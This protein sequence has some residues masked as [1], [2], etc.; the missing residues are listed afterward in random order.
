MKIWILEDEDFA[1]RKIANLL[2]KILPNAEVGEP[3]ESVKEATQALSK[4]QPDLL[5]ADIHLSDGLSFELFDNVQVE[6]P[7]IFTTA[8]DEYALKAF[9][10]MSVDYLLKPISE[11]QLRKAIDKLDQFRKGAPEAKALMETLR[12][13]NKGKRVFKERFL[14]PDGQHFKIIKAD[15]IAHFM[16]DGKFTF[17]IDKGGKEYLIDQNLS[18]LEELLNPTQFFRLNRAI[19]THIDSIKR[20]HPY[21]QSKLLVDLDPPSKKE[22]SISSDK[23]RAFKEWLGTGIPRPH[24][25]GNPTTFGQD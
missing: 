21:G 11:D 14:V 10:L 3:I 1:G 16:G 6:C 5:L 25:Q 13:L 2:Q 18:Q 7:I 19:I 9:E 23:S 20:V 24:L 15:E 12:E 4:E 17:L 22:A 8:F